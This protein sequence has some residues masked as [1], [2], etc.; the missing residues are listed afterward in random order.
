MWGRT[1]IDHPFA[2]LSFDEY[3]PRRGR[4]ALIQSLIERI[5]YVFIDSLEDDVYKQDKQRKS[6]FPNLRCMLDAREPGIRPKEYDLILMCYDFNQTV[7]WVKDGDFEN[8]LYIISQP[9]QMLDQY[10]LHV[11]SQHDQ[12]FSRFDFSPWAQPPGVDVAIT[13]EQMNE[14]EEDEEDESPSLRLDDPELAGKMGH[15]PAQLRLGISFSLGINDFEQNL[16]RGNEWFWE[17][18]KSG[19]L[20]A[21]YNW[22]CYWETQPD[23]KDIDFLFYKDLEQMHA[24]G[25]LAA[26]YMLGVYYEQGIDMHMSNPEL[27][28]EYYRQAA[29]QGFAPAINNLADKYEK[30][31]GVRQD[32]NQA[33]ALY[34]QAAG[35]NIAA[36]QWSLAL[37][38]LNGE[39]VEKDQVQAKYYLEIAL[40]NGWENAA[41]ILE[42]LEI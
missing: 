5:D 20:V 32:L 6:G 15:V 24:Q 36:A 31:L 42:S 2:W 34:Q 39:P 1:L 9:Q 12:E 10:F 27:A 21:Q 30:G 25:N 17:A 37:M 7:Y 38:Y 13:A 29:D 4:K 3:L 23:F 41:T 35:Q 33:Y 22:A 11:F 16:K 19:D 18:T 40:E 26:T 28:V 8:G 14:I